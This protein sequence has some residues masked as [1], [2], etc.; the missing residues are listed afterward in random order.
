MCHALNRI[1]WNFLTVAHYE[2]SCNFRHYKWPKLPWKL[3]VSFKKYVDERN[4]MFIPWSSENLKRI[5]F[6]VLLVRHPQAYDNLW[7]TPFLALRSLSSHQK[8][9]RQLYGKWLRGPLFELVQIYAVRV[10]CLDWARKFSC[11]GLMCLAFYGYRQMKLLQN[12]SCNIFIYFI[13][14]IEGIFLWLMNENWY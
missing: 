3:N 6:E 5:P 13:V 4:G 9:L 12:S 8:W 14:F 1:V 10:Y 2:L 11:K 7:V